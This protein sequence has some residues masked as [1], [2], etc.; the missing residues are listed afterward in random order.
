MSLQLSICFFF[1]SILA[2]I[3]SSSSPVWNVITI[4]TDGGLNEADL[5]SILIS[6]ISNPQ[7]FIA[8]DAG[9]LRIISN[10]H[11]SHK[12]KGTIYAGLKKAQEK[13][14]LDSFTTAQEEGGLSRMGSFFTEKLRAY[15][16]SHPHFVFSACFFF[17]YLN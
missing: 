5:T 7:H 12:E 9:S 14:S 4:G 15:L 8:L 2:S 6:P 17:L 13:G 10:S 1:L 16:I 3:V 11:F